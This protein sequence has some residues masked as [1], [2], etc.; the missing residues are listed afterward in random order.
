MTLTLL[1]Q[2]VQK[3][4]QTKGIS[5]AISSVEDL[6]ADRG[7][8]LSP[9]ERENL[10][11]ALTKMKEQYSA[12]TDSANTSLSD[13]DE[14][15][16]NTVQ[17]NTQRVR[18]RPYFYFLLIWFIESKVNPSVFVCAGK[19]RRR[20]PGDTRTDP[21]A[22]GPAVL[23]GPTG[24]TISNTRNGSECLW[25]PIHTARGRRRVTHRDAAGQ[26]LCSKVYIFFVFL[27]FTLSFYLTWQLWCCPPG[28]AA[29][30]S[31]SAGPASPD[32]PV[33]QVS[34][35]TARLHG[36]SGGE[37]ASESSPGAAAGSAPG[38]TAELP[39]THRKSWNRVR[40]GGVNK[41]R[42][43]FGLLTNVSVSPR[44]VWGS[45][46]LW[47]T[48]SQSSCRNTEDCAPGWNR[49]NRSSV[50]WGRERP[51]HRDWRGDWR[52]TGRWRLSFDFILLHLVACTVGGAGLQFSDIVCVF[53]LTSKWS[54]KTRKYL[55]KVSI[56]SDSH[57]FSKIFWFR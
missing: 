9:E 51:T 23:S 38:E 48:S 18:M 39:G 20:T 43:C 7:E 31:G 50:P 12:L 6:L 53:L 37:A 45:P 41:R 54:R 29:A 27:F 34:A 17:Q 32:Q 25:F 42:R 14:A 49:V 8:S 33:H 22:P 30:A 5:E 19:G 2:E 35:G 21:H 56:W 26:T 10:Q 3:D 16:N 15:I 28:G 4:L 13:L 52:S 36:S 44:S 1:F 40:T 55:K 47:R 57:N 24:E 11:R 46:R